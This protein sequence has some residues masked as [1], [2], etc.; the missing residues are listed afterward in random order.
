LRHDADEEASTRTAYARL[1]HSAKMRS[2]TFESV[3]EFMKAEVS[4]EM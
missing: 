1:A 3:E 4:D 2:Q